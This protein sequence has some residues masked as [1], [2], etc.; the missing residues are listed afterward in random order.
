MFKYFYRISDLHD[1]YDITSIS[2]FT[3]NDETYKPNKFEKSLFGMELSYKYNTYKILDQKEIKLK[4]SDN[5][6]AFI[7][8]ATLYSL[9]SKN[10]Q[11]MKLKSKIELT[12]ILFDKN[13]TEETIIDIFEFINLFISFRDEKFDNLFYAELEKMPKTKEKE[14]LNSYDKFLLNKG[15]KE[16]AKNL[17]NLG[18]EIESISKATSLSVKEIEKM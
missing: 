9:R 13:Y 12:K 7:V 16:I 15:K 10:N 5:I 2:I 8:L 4:K 6:F 3:D 11:K 14:L 1:T 18:V 17:K